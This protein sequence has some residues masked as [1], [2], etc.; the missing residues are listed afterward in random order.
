MVLLFRLPYA[1]RGLQANFL[2][3]EYIEESKGED[4]RCLVID[5]KVVGYILRSNKEN[6]FRS[7]LH[8][9]GVAE[10]TTITDVYELTHPM[11]TYVEN[12]MVAYGLID[13]TPTTDMSGAPQGYWEVSLG[14][15]P[16]YKVDQH[17]NQLHFCF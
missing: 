13:F 1:F 4:L 5:G 16:F 8:Q 11:G 7:N 9:G 10:S 2:V 12:I 3:Q 15:E 17:T 14:A 6:D